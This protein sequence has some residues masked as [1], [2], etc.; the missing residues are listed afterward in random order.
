MLIA[1]TVLNMF[2]Y[3]FTYLFYTGINK[4]RDKIWNSWTAKVRDGVTCIW[5]RSDSPIIGATR[6][7][8]HY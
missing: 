2:L 4:R 7:S 1:I 3:L 8:G 5:S 6:V